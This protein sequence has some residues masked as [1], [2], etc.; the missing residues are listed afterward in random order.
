MTRRAYNREETMYLI[1]DLLSH[2]VRLAL[3]AALLLVGL[4]VT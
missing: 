1:L 3:L 4:I 2:S